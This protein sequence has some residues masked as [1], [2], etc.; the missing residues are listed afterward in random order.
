MKQKLGL[1]F[2]LITTTM[3]VNAQNIDGDWKGLLS[4][5]GVDQELPGN[6][7]LVSPDEEL[8]ALIA[9]DKGNYSYSVSDY[10][11]RPNASSFR[12]SP[13]GKYLSYMEKEGLKNHVYIREIATGKVT[14]LCKD[15]HRHQEFLGFLKH[16]ARA[17]P[18]ELSGGQRQRVV[19]AIA[20]ANDP[21]LLICDEPTTALDV[22]VQAQILRLLDELQHELGLTYVFIAHDLAVVRQISDTVSVMSRGR[23][24]EAGPTERVFRAP[25]SDFTRQLID[26]IPGRRY[27]GGDLN[28]GL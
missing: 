25:E 20:L 26:A 22:T 12:L 5:Q 4:V 19:L 15:R 11:A 6:P 10:F 2:A 9:L 7:A 27:R 8:Q 13:D 23:Q 14:G 21:A 28:L 16:V 18:H 17:Y 1:F 3:M 24:V